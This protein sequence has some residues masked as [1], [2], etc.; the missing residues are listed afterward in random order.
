MWFASDNA[1]P[2]HPAVLDALARANEGFAASYGADEAHGPGD[3][4]AARDLRGARGGGVPRRHR[5]GGE[6]A[7]ARLPVPALGDG[8]LPH[9]TRMS[10]RTSAARSASTPA[11]RR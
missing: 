10:R 11:A 3:G 6:R 8:V 4:A 7:V 9:A 5:H 1:G 2:A